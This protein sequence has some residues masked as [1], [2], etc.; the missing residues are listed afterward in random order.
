MR[1]HKNGDKYLFILGVVLFLL[2]N[3]F[4][5]KDGHNWGGDF[6]QYIRHAKNIVEHKDYSHGLPLDSWV[7][8]T[9]GFPLVLVPF[10]K[11]FGI[12]FKVFKTVNVVFWLLFSLSFYAIAKKRLKEEPALLVFM[13]LLF[14]HFFFIFKQQVLS[15]VPFLF[16]LTFSIVL[17]LKFL[18]SQ[19]GAS[20][21]RQW[22]FFIAAMVFMMFAALVRHA[23]L[24]LFVSVLI[25]SLFQKKAAKF[26]MAAVCAMAAVIF[27]Q[28]LFGASGA[29]H[30]H[31]IQG[32]WGNMFGVIANNVVSVLG[33][34]MIYFIPIPAALMPVLFIVAPLLMIVITGLFF[35][36]IK[37]KK[38]EF[39]ECFF[40]VY[41]VGVLVWPLGL[42]EV[43]RY[44]LPLMG[45]SLVFCIE[46]FGLA[47][48]K[49]FQQRFCRL[50][51]SVEQVTRGFLLLILFFNV[52]NIR[53]QFSFNDDAIFQND[54]VEMMNW[55]KA[56]TREDEHFLFRR[57]RV[58]GLFTDRLG[59]QLTLVKGYEGKFYWRVRKFSVRWLI[60][61]KNIFP[62]NFEQM[63]NE[64]FVFLKVFENRSFEI[65]KVMRRELTKQE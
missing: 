34:I 29:G 31:E 42:Q 7:V 57:P 25:Y 56:N 9:P 37:T 52:L 51:L 33:T 54:A 26:M 40:V 43:Q 13:V 63:S 3:I 14:S 44:A 11:V 21:K 4:T 32:P 39:V 46:L 28:A 48:R 8:C 65:Y 62:F 24:L 17:Y 30:F 22:L 27:L 41:L 47:W 61:D 35:Y 49:Y 38:L 16:F 10:V 58:V 15:D 50:R 36:R 2:I 20:L 1:G 45:L 64:E 53:M 60:N 18:E 59:A 5:I 6:S 23:G 12:Q 55:V 19:K